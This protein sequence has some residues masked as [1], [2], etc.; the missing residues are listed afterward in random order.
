MGEGNFED[1]ENLYFIEV[2]FRNNGARYAAMQ[3]LQSGDAK[4]PF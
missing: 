2:P 4:K 1:L 3:R